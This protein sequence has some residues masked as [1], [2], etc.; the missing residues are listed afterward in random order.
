MYTPQGLL[1]LLRQR[2]DSLDEAGFNK[3][4]DAKLFAD[5][6]VLVYARP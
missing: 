5:E 3:A 6:Y 2:D 1:P 4:D